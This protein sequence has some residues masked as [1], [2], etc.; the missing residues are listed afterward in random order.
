MERSP[1]SPSR[2]TS[3]LRGE[4]REHEHEHEHERERERG[5]ATSPSPPPRRVAAFSS[6]PTRPESPGSY[7]ARMQ[8]VL[9]HVEQ[10][11]GAGSA[12]TGAS[13]NSDGETVGG[14]VGGTVAPIEGTRVVQCWEERE[15]G[16][17]EQQQQQQ[18]HQPC[19]AINRAREVNE[20]LAFSEEPEI[21]RDIEV[22]IAA[23]SAMV[24][25]LVPEQHQWLLWAACCA[26]TVWFP[27]RRH[28]GWPP[29]L[30]ASWCSSPPLPPPRPSPPSLTGDSNLD[31]NQPSPRPAYPDQ[32]PP[33]PPYTDLGGDGDVDAAGLGMDASPSA[34]GGAP[35]KNAESAA[36]GEVSGERYRQV[37]EGLSESE[38]DFVESA[39]EEEKMRLL[40]QCLEYANYDTVGAIKVC[41][42]FCKF[43]QSE[44]WGLV[45][46]AEELEG[47]LR[48]RVHTLTAGRDR[49]GRGMITFTPGKLDVKKAPPADYHKMLC[50]VLQEVLKD[51]ELQTKGLVLL[52][53]AR[54]VGFR[55]L[56]HFTMADYR[57]GLRMLGGAFPAKIKAIRILHINRAIGIAL[58]VAM[59]L[60]SAKMRDRQVLLYRS[61][62]GGRLLPCVPSPPRLIGRRAPHNQ[63]ACQARRFL[64]FFVSRGRPPTPPTASVSRVV[65]SGC[66]RFFA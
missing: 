19:D 11:T 10:T 22:L 41:S 43:R 59:P 1:L 13:T 23:V 28:V 14:T 18:Q 15:C 53:D 61:I 37:L 52:V 48:S 29:S 58:S 56:R 44:G 7:V 54:D 17:A 36:V 50:Y 21:Q 62:L 60:L 27:M 24:G 47:P 6:P 31:N 63:R 45:L 35:K 5:N 42:T 32:L 8:R 51:E 55:M 66:F 30:R 25:M 3:R 4:K 39:G 64:F 33:P 26:V 38:T 57:R 49:T 20:A 46:S 2:S 34:G 65:M 40:H 9:A 16:E 12:S